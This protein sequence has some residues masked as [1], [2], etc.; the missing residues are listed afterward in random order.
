M[1]NDDEELAARNSPAFPAYTA[2]AQAGG[3]NDPEEVTFEDW[4]FD[5]QAF[6]GGWTAAMIQSSQTDS[7]LFA[8][9]KELASV[10]RAGVGKGLMQRAHAAVAKE[11]DGR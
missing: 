10:K 5:W 6:Y 7:E 2:W 9:V 3:G 1:A 11:E 4:K 8:I